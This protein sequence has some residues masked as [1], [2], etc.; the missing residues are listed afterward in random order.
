MRFLL[1]ATA[2][3]GVTSIA[4]GDG[5]DEINEWR[6]RCGLKPFIEDPKMTEFAAKKAR[7]R[8]ERNLRDGHQ[9]PKPPAGW[10]E[11][12]GEAKPFWGWLT[13]ESESDFRYAGAAMCVGS[14]GTRYMVLVCREGTGR[15]LISRNN[16]P[17]HNTSFMTPDPPRVGDATAASVASVSARPESRIVARKV[18][19]GSEP[20]VPS[21]NRSTQIAPAQIAPPAVT[22]SK[23]C[24]KCGKIH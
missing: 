14:D 9:G 12:T 1:L 21:K 20:S 22:T 2:L 24:P 8:A 13:C 18:V 23:R 15:A 5:F 17:V 7:Y 16:A 19:V 11:G 3:V 4:Y 6:K 10:H